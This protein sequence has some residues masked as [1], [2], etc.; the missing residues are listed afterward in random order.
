MSDSRSKPPVRPRLIS[1]TESPADAIERIVSRRH[2]QLEHG[3][4]LIVRERVPSVNPKPMSKVPQWRYRVSVHPESHKGQVYTS[5]PHA[6]S[7][8]EQLASQRRCRLMF[9]ED[10]IPS[11]LSDHRR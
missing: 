11:L 1:P 2:L 3:D 8:A 7:H 6:A 9:V 4:V 10:D 5:F